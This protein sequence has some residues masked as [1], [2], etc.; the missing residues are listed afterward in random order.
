MLVQI[1]R[2]IRTN[3]IAE[4]YFLR[5]FVR[6]T[7]QWATSEAWNVVVVVYNLRCEAVCVL[8]DV[9]LRYRRC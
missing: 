3:R 8:L 5:E 9:V 7:N 2:Q 6:L 1:S 4:L